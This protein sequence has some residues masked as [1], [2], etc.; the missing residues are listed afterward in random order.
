MLIQA[1]L[2]VGDTVTLKLTSGEEVVGRFVAKAEDG[3]HVRKPVTFM[4][5]A[6]GLGLVPYAF[7]APEDITMVFP[8]HIIICSFKTD[9]Q[10]ASQYIKQS[11]GLAI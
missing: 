3:I 1:P 11:T 4:M 7:S 6:Q 5:G 10:V 2:T 9:S 8:M